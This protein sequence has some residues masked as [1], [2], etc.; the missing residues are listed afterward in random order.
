MVL[1]GAVSGLALG[2]GSVHYIQPLLYQVRSTELPVL[3]IPS[4]AIFGAAVLAAL[5]AVIHAVEID[6][7]ALLS[8]E[9]EPLFDNLREA[10]L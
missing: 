10:V 6:P 4:L 7:A 3:L 1:V 5:P 8:A 9:Y 2:L